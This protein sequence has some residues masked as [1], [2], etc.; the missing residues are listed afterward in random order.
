MMRYAILPWTLAAAACAACLVA[1]PATAENADAPPFY[2]WEPEVLHLF[3]TLPVQDEGR[4]KPLDTLAQFALLRLNGRRTFEFENDQG[5]TVTL[6]HLEWFLT[7]MFHREHVQDWAHFRIDNDELITAI[8]IPVHDRKRDH[9]SYA[10]LRE[11]R[12]ALFRIAAEADAKQSADRDLLERQALNLAS[13]ML[14]FEKIT[15]FLDFAYMRF[16][17]EGDSQLSAA[18]PEAE[19][20]PMSEALRRAPAVLNSLRGNPQGLSD[21]EVDREVQAFAQ[22]MEEVDLAG[23]TAV[24]L[25]FFPPMAPDERVW[26]TPA[27]M[28][29]AA[30]IPGFQLGNRLDMLSSL[31]RLALLRND[32]EAFRTELETFHAGLEAAATQRGEYSKIP[33]EVHFYNVG[34]LW[35]SLYL[36][37]FS[38]IIIALSWLLP[39][40][41]WIHWGTW[42]AV[43]APTVL[44]VLGITLRCII[45]S[46]PPVSTLYETVLF[47]TAVAVVLALIIEL[48][49]KQRIAVATASFLGTLGMFLAFRYEAKEG[50]D[51]M[52]AL[53]AVLD[54][55]FWLATH[56]TTITIG[57]AAGLLA[58]ALAHIY[59]LGKLVK[60]K[61]KEPAFYRNI[62]RLTYGTICF[63][64]IFSVVGTILGGIWA[65][66]SWGRFWGWDPKENGALMICLWTIIIL[67]AKM[68][69][70]IKD[71]GVAISAVLLGCIVAF[72]WWGTNNLGVGLHSYG[73]T[74][75]LWFALGIFWGSQ[76]FVMLL[77]L[78]VWIR[79]TLNPPTLPPEAPVEKAGKAKPPKPRHA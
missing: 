15:R 56:V 33:L 36:F 40:N 24:M 57:Y 19:G 16:V 71:L 43:A 62:A 27:D 41:R 75:G 50:V 52:P 20:V 59:I 23:Q 54:T 25:A 37:G 29:G 74:S 3:A 65:N 31:E 66:D 45:R 48:F 10:E 58:G 64:L 1:L 4:V 39:Y 32:R 49:N 9:Y 44:L 28:R 7:A 63:S 61:A 11:G 51:T 68:G 22:L 21:A 60:F 46:R 5:Q 73:F 38:F 55:N 70:Y 72:S 69:R 67:H 42:A 76:A 53:I 79:D 34:Y 6:N 13:N 14:T 2:E 47:I 30:F 77:G 78:V 35:Y 8:Q 17:V 26:M 12:E 18:F